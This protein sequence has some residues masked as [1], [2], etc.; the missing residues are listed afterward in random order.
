MAISIYEPRDDSDYFR[1]L[2]AHPDGY[3]VNT[4]PGGRGY[5]LLHRAAC[6][7]IRNRPPHIGPSYV[8]VC[9]TSETELQGRVTERR[10][11][12]APRCQARGCG[13]WL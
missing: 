4:E 12:P 2:A 1:W 13:C 6:D 9:S 11:E 3:V 10:G 8:K 5:A 7:T